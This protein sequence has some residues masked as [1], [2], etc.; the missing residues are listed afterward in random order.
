[1]ESI[2]NL[3]FKDE[4]VL[5]EETHHIKLDERLRFVI[6]ILMLILMNL[7]ILIPL[8]NLSLPIALE[9]LFRYFLIILITMNVLMSAMLLFS[10]F[11]TLKDMKKGQLTWKDLKKYEMISILTNK[12]WIQKDRGVIFLK[13]KGYSTGDI[14]HYKDFVFIKLELIKFIELTEV[15][16]L[17]K[18]KYWIKLYFSYDKKKPKGEILGTNFSSTDQFL[19][20]LDNIKGVLK[21]KH[22]ENDQVNKN[23]KKYRFYY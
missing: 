15:K 18:M 5:W 7:F 10:F 6:L 19:I 2:K 14:E 11:G 20:L 1:M 23:M 8:R 3:L 16:D 22:E 12:R 21:I 4:K 17:G 13:D 9:S